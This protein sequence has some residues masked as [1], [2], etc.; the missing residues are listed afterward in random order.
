MPLHISD[1]DMIG[2]DGQYPYPK[3]WNQ[4]L[5]G[6]GKLVFDGKSVFALWA[7]RAHEAHEAQKREGWEAQQLQWEEQQL[8]EPPHDEP[9]V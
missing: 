2:L 5:R 8:T 3:K 7:A 4:Q 9:G 1:V 6:L